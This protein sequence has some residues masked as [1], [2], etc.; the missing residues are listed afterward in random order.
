MNR[1]GKLKE[2]LRSK[3]KNFNKRLG[4]ERERLA[5][6]EKEFKTHAKEIYRDWLDSAAGHG[7]KEPVLRENIETEEVETEKY[8]GWLE[9]VL[10]KILMYKRFG[11][12]E[13]E[14][15]LSEDLNSLQ[16]DLNKSEKNED[17]EMKSE[18]IVSKKE[19]QS[20]REEKEQVN[21]D[22]EDTALPNP[23]EA[24]NFIFKIRK[25]SL[26]LI[27]MKMIF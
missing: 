14:I 1:Q 13:E 5:S 24:V 26:S 18:E 16:K 20:T 2:L 6:I 15:I 8:L 11:L 19:I 25:A 9:F 12:E 27:V 17:I 23:S 3:F 22:N 21:S 10:K 4:K 7:V